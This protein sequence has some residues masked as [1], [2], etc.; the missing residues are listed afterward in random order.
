MTG[1]VSP[2]KSNRRTE[3]AQISISFIARS[4]AA[5][6]NNNNDLQEHTTNRNPFFIFS[7]IVCLWASFLPSVLIIYPHHDHNY[8]LLLLLLCFTTDVY[9]V[10]VGFWCLIFAVMDPDGRSVG[11]TDILWEY[12]DIRTE[13]II[14]IYQLVIK[15]LKKRPKYIHIKITYIYLYF[16]PDV[17]ACP[18]VRPSACGQ[19]C[20]FFFS[21]YVFILFVVKVCVCSFYS[22]RNNAKKF[23][24]EFS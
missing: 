3:G 7:L 11:Q 24:T 19:V 14:H 9:P 8:Y 21:V 23:F 6:H 1:G 4:F 12:T 17:Y 18:S 20:V 13:H 5:S 22:R 16:V 15:S 10:V 2:S